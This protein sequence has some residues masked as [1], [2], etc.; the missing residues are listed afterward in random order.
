MRN[1]ILEEVPELTKISSKGQVVIPQEYREKLH[2]HEGNVFAVTAPTEDMI[3]LKKIKN[4][5]LRDD[6]TTLKKID[7]AWE[8]IEKGEFEK[9]TKKEFLKKLDK[10]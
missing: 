9:T 1:E 5:M 2:I 8:E 6:L 4:P 3:V 10:W 7:E